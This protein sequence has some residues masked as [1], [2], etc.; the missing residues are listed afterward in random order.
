[1]KVTK[2]ISYQE[3]I[4]LYDKLSRCNIITSQNEYR[5]SFMTK[6]YY[7]MIQLANIV[8]NYEIQ[9]KQLEENLSEDIDGY[10]LQ[11]KDLLKNVVQIEIAL[12]DGYEADETR[13]SYDTIKDI[14][15]MVN[16]ET[17]VV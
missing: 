14:Y 6:F 2:N 4:V 7:N 10:N 5:F 16:L 13:I 8:N 11:N 9:R 15:F 12:I 3:A 17:V 1:M